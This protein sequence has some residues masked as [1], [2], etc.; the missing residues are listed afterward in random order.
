MI[1]ETFGWPAAGGRAV[2]CR[3]LGLTHLGQRH[4]LLTF[5]RVADL[6]APPDV[7]GVPQHPKYRVQPCCR[8]ELEVHHYRSLNELFE[9]LHPSDHE[10]LEVVSPAADH[11]VRQY[12]LEHV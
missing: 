10:E 8:C 12:R 7:E 4:L 5:V 6:E 11:H 1:T 3:L 9:A 2:S